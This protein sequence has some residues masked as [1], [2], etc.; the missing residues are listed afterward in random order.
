MVEPL[1]KLLASRCAINML[2]R[3][4]DYI[5][6]CVNCTHKNICNAGC[7]SSARAMHGTVNARDANCYAI[8]CLYDHIHNVIN[9]DF[10]INHECGNN[11][12]IQ[13]RGVTLASDM[14]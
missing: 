11:M 14:C 9:H 12:T 4:A 5:Q 10:L 6:E 2:A 7:P 8:K 13:P 1:D 3:K